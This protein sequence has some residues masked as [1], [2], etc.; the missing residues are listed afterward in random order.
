MIKVQVSPYLGISEWVDPHS[1]ITFSKKAGII[2]IPDGA[3]LTSINKY[4]RLNQLFVVGGTQPVE[5]PVV[6]T[7]VIEVEK[8]LKAEE[9][10]QIEVEPIKVEVEKIDEEVVKEAA[11]VV[12]TGNR[13]KKKN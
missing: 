9:V 12:K 7:P 11:P 10:K 8:S 4:I 3:D 1:G 6:D 13:T 5:K 2:Q